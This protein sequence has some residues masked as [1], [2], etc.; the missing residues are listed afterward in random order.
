MPVKSLM[1]VLGLPAGDLRRPLRPLDAPALARGVAIV[2]ALGLDATYGF[3][4]SAVGLPAA[5]EPGAPAP[6]AA[7]GPPCT[8]P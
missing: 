1:T 2:R 6:A 7:P 8:L 3:K 4:V 5:A